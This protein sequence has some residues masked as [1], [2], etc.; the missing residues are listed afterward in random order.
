L[1]AP[2]APKHL[3]DFVAY[4]G[5]KNSSYHTVSNYTRDILSFLKYIKSEVSQVTHQELQNFIS[6]QHLKGLS[7]AS[8]RRKLSSIRSFYK[9]LLDRD[10]VNLNPAEGIRLPKL[11]KKLP[12]VLDVDQMSGLLNR[13]EQTEDL[14]I[15]DFAMFELMYSS[16]LRVSEISGLDISMLK[17]EEG[18]VKVLGK[19]SKQRIVPVGNLA[20]KA[21][22]KWLK[23]RPNMLKEYSEALFIGKNG[24]RLGVRSIQKRLDRLGKIKHLEQHVSPHMLRHSFASHMLES[25]GDLRA[26]QEMLG[27]SDISTTQIYTHLNFQYLAKVYDKAHPRATRK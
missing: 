26:V 14:L 5:S 21:L 15:R 1:T 4:L 3:N 2:A 6:E 12:K 27:H 25:S 8:L 13:N 20:L 9:F 7:P 10:L 11:E 18:M 19:G 22:D 24:T 16:G 17:L 23:I